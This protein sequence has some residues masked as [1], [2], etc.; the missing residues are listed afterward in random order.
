MLAVGSTER[1]TIDYGHLEIQQDHTNL[2][3]ER[4]V[5]RFLSVRHDQGRIPLVFEQLVKHLADVGII[6]GNEDRGA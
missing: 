6:L 1:F 2:L 3:G 4:E 5:K